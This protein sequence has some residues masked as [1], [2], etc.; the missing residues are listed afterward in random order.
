MNFL[1]LFKREPLSQAVEDFRIN[2]EL[3]TSCKIFDH[4]STTSLEIFLKLFND[5]KVKVFLFKEG[6]SFNF[7]VKLNPE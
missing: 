5:P 4:V 2:F 7:L 1:N 6:S 3:G